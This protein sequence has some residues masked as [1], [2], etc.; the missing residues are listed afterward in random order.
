MYLPS[1]GGL[2][3]AGANQK[4]RPRACDEFRRIAVT[5]SEKLDCA[6]AADEHASAAANM[7]M[8]LNFVFMSCVYCSYVVSFHPDE[9]AEMVLCK[10]QW[11][12]ASFP[13]VT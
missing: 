7:T 2:F 10:N 13:E 4:S 6:K 11:M 9:N 1:P 12:I 3:S 8:E 5:D